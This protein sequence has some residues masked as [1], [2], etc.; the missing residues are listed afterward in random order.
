MNIILQNDALEEEE[1]IIKNL[2]KQSKYLHTFSLKCLKELDDYVYNSGDVPIGTIEY[3][4]K[5]LG[6]VGFTH[7]QPIE[8]P[9]Y[10]QTEEFLKRDYK[11][12]T[13]KDIP[14]MGNWFIKD[15]STLKNFSICT[16]MTYFYS[17]ELFDYVPKTKFDNTLSL[18][19]ASDYVIS[20]P[21]NIQAEYRVYVIGEV[22][23]HIV[24][25][26]GSPLCQPDIKLIQ[27][28]VNLINYNEKWLTSYS[29]DIMVGPKG[30]AIVEVH[31]FNSLG[32]YTTIWG[33]GLLYAYRDSIDYL[34][35]DNSVKFK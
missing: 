23:E 2:L 35:N 32:L 6:N 29:L 16:D 21:Y 31:N 18:S 15:A 17:D 5:A 22:I 24:L 33:T 25:Y 28:A 14:K 12:G 19:K 8:I 7:Q 1:F 10:L 11:I 20:S 3:V 4:T 27:K 13:W 9:K 34:L 30:T 26:D